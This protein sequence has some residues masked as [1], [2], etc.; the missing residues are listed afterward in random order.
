MTEPLS[1]ADRPSPVA[2]LRAVSRAFRD[3]WGRPTVRAVVDVTLEIRPGEIFGL[4]GPNGSG[5]STT[6]K[7]LLGL[8][9]PD[10]GAI[11]VFGL[12]PTARAARAR[13]GYLPE[14]NYVYQHFT[15]EEVLGFYG[16]L[17]NL[18][19]DELQRRIGQLLDMIGL[20]HARN[21]TLGGF[22]KGMARR[23]GLAQALINDP[24]LVVLDEPTSGLD[25]V[26]CRQVKDLIR[27]LS[28]RGK[29]IVLSSHLLAD[30]EDVCHRVG[31]MHHGRMAVQGPVHELLE[32]RTQG[33]L[34]FPAPDAGVLERAAQA[35][36][37]AVGAPPLIDRPCCTLEQ[38][39]LKQL[40]Q[41]AS[42]ASAPTGVSLATGLAE[43]LQ[44]LAGRLEQAAHDPDARPQADDPKHLRRMVDA[45]EP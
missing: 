33:R 40:E 4:L 7:L 32:D 13:L 14:D 36:Q 45:E 17:F 35:V 16:R 26:G 30:V 15:P 19:S 24:E 43:Y 18:R 10:Q 27:M 11:R 44:P 23:I 29:T 41:D 37:Q 20:Q 34:T 22:S 9:R 21:R 12:S 25:P 1:N 6:L 5:K 28:A 38:F 31:I 39:F 2:E 8:L 3:F 42:Q